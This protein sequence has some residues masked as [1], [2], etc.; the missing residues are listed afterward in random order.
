V[1][2]LPH[3]HGRIDA[4]RLAAH[5]SKWDSLAV[6]VDAAGAVDPAVQASARKHIAVWLSRANQSFVRPS[7]EQLGTVG[8][9]LD[10]HRGSLEEPARST[11]H[12]LVTYWRSAE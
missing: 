12:Q 1:R 2:D 4:L 7:R 10:D 11:L 9:A 5:L 6:L 3:G 8:R